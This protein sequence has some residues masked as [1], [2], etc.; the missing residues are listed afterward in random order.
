MH[1]LLCHTSGIADYCEEDEDSPAYLEDY[2]ALWEERPSYSIE[3]P[4]DF[5]PL[6]ARPAAV[7]RLRARRTS[8]ATPATS[9]SAW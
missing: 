2:G 3:R 9:C 6:F 5:L 1:H 4:V 7:P 8:T